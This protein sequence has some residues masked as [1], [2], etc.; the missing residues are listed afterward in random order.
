MI[1]R[2]PT[3]EEIARLLDPQVW[4][5][6]DSLVHVF[7][8]DALTEHSPVVTASLAKATRVRMIYLEQIG[9]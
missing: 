8:K 4:K 7:S 2:I 6:V 5:D 9:D 3:T 1:R